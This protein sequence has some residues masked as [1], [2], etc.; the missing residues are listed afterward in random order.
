MGIRR[1][2]LPGTARPH[3]LAPSRPPI[4]AAY[5]LG[6]KGKTE[7]PDD[8]EKM[9]DPADCEEAACVRDRTTWNAVRVV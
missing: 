1:L 3:A 5:L 4:T 9:A 2:A 7:C 8:F 6:D